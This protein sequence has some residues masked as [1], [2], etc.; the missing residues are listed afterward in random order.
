M[1]FMIMAFMASAPGGDLTDRQRAAL[2]ALVSDLGT[3][4]GSRLHALVAYGLDLDDA[5]ND[6]R[7]L[8]LFE[9]VTFDDLARAQKLPGVDFKR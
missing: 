5:A 8:G 2:Q 1:A 4:F 6:V 9:R 7:T 3:I